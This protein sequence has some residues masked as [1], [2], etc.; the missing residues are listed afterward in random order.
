[1]R[2]FAKYDLGPLLSVLAVAAFPCIFIFAQNCEEVAPVSMVPFLLV[3]TVLGLGLT[4][5][6]SAIFRNVSRGAF[7]A[8]LCL[9]VVINFCLLAENV[10][11]VLP[12]L[13]DRWQLVILG[14]LLLA[15]FVLLLRKKPNMVTPCLLVLIAFGSMI[16][17]NLIFAVPTMLEL[18]RE[19]SAEK[20]QSELHAEFGENRPNVYYFVFDEYG[21]YENLLYYYNYD[22]SEFLEALEERGFSVARESRNTEAV[23]TVTILPN[24]LNLD[25][26]VALEDSKKTKEDWVHNTAMNRIF[27]EN[28]YQVQMINHIDAL[29]T[30]NAQVL[31]KEQTRRTISE[32][33]LKNSLFNK[34]PRAKKLL[35]DLFSLDY[36]SNYRRC[37]DNALDAGMNA[38]KTAQ[39]GPT[40]TIGYIQCPHSPTMVGRHGEEM[41]F[42][43]GWN[44]LDHSL[45][46]NQLGFVSDYIL[47]LVD[48]I[49]KN[50][51]E[52]MIILQSDHGNRYPIHMWQ[53][54]VLESY[55]PYVE[56]PYM[57]N[58]LN[59][60]YYQ[61][62][63]FP[64]EGE[65]GINTLRL[66]FRE[67]LGADLPP[68]EPV[69]TYFFGY[70]D[71]VE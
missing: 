68:V 50:D 20:P 48:T 38:W 14:L 40:L 4:A 46:L 26:V 2:H 32:I 19:A 16:V 71:E 70:E 34:M 64:I 15:V 18:R 9:L 52:A 51:P 11:K 63:S 6:F 47:E 36:S 66:M 58:I 28:G 25:Y 69:Y 44:W 55:D 33:L 53:M 62:E 31:T 3:Y 61:G 39:D 27:R 56:E 5:L 43:Q 8:D 13:W 37:L 57:K 65:N 17:M 7:L 24:L 29:G 49:Q 1:M 23:E 67:V 21:G 35:D 59:C 22:N 60:V 45:Y 42:S 54:K 30:E 41:P 12:F 10:K